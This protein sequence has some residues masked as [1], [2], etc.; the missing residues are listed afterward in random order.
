LL[1][2]PGSVFSAPAI[3][4]LLIART[5]LFT[6]RQ[7]IVAAALVFLAFLPWTLYQKYYDPPGNRLLKMHLAGVMEPDARGTF[8]ALPD[9]YAH[10]SAARI[11]ENKWSN[12]KTSIMLFPNPWPGLRVAEREYVP[13]A[14]GILVLAWL[15]AMR[16][17]SKLPHTLGVVG[18]AVLNLLVWSFVLFGPAQTVTEH[19]SYADIFLLSLSFIGV[20]LAA[21]PTVSAAVLALQMLN[22]IFVWVWFRPASFVLP[23]RAVAGPVVQWP[24]LVIGIVVGSGLFWFF[25]TRLFERESTAAVPDTLIE[26]QTQ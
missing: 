4:A 25:A 15:T 14:I 17:R 26:Q 7:A 21:P 13:Y 8:Q 16:V 18:A 10:V 12:V 3:L 19:G 9:A 11:V 6:W 5:R 2:H 20:I 1:A 23:T 24:M 22:L